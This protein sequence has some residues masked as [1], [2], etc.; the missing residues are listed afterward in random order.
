M[1]ED[2]TLY[3]SGIGR[4]RPREEAEDALQVGPRKKPYVILVALSVS[5]TC[6]VLSVVS[7]IRS[8]TMGGTLVERNMRYA[9]SE[10]C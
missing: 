6:V 4:L 9:A 2:E 3:V 7:L 10:L 8:Y 5:S 1:S